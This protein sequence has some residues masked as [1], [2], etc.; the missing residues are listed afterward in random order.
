MS[1]RVRESAGDVAIGTDGINATALTGE[2]QRRRAHREAGEK[3][4][5]VRR[6][7]KPGG[8]A[9][10]SGEAGGRRFTSRAL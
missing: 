3:E 6:G 9:V 1:R 4:L 8:F 2:I 7:R 5:G 10:G